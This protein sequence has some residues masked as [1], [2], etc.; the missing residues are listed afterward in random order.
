MAQIFKELTLQFTGSFGGI[1]GVKK[2][3]GGVYYRGRVRKINDANTDAQKEKRTHLKNIVALFQRFK[4]GLK[5]G[6]A[7]KKGTHSAYNAFVRLNSKILAYGFDP[8]SPTVWNSLALESPNIPQ[9]GVTTFTEFT[10]T[11][12]NTL[13]LK[14]EYV[15][16]E[17]AAD[18]AGLLHTVRAFDAG[19][20]K[21][22]AVT[23]EQDSNG[24]MTFYV[25]LTAR[26]MG[27]GQFAARTGRNPRTGAELRISTPVTVANQTGT[28][29]PGARIV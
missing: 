29:P 6:F 10:D 9:E 21:G 24:S 4:Q 7:Y 22:V 5:G 26:G 15:P 3:G 16:T 23:V 8:E 20:S 13:Y 19:A 17:N 18:N 14:V 27:V 12:T 28:I 25:D 1:T 11:N 2:K